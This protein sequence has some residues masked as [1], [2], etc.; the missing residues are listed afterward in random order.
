VF[1]EIINNNKKLE[2]GSPVLREAVLA[3]DRP[4]FC[5]LKRYFAILSTV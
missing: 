2:P 1:F 4:A 5:R 3:I